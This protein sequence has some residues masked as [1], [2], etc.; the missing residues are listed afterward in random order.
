MRICQTELVITWLNPIELAMINYEDY[1]TD[2]DFVD[3]DN[4]EKDEDYGIYPDEPY[5][6]NYEKIKKSNNHKG[7]YN[8]S[9]KKQERH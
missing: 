5:P 7:G 8:A 2:D 9:R 1:E 3:F 6:D 4:Y